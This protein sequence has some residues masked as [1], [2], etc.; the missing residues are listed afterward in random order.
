[1]HENVKIC[2]ASEREGAEFGGEGRVLNSDGRQKSL[3]FP[4]QNKIFQLR[5]HNYVN[6][7]IV[8]RYRKI[9]LS[10]I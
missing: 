1:V 4:I 10:W 8:Y 9:I 3:I 6:Q 2:E 7:T 5:T